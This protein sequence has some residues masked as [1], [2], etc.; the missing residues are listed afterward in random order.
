MSP[1]ADQAEHW[2]RT[3][4]AQSY[5]QDRELKRRR[6]DAWEFGIIGLVAFASV[7]AALI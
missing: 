2:N 1:H 7:I 5:I 3:M 6:R 4:A